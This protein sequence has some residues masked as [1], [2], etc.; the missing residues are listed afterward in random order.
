MFGFQKKLN[1]VME[2]LGILN[3]NLNCFK[4]IEFGHSPDLIQAK[5][6]IRSVFYL[7]KIFLSL[8]IS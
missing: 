2:D 7:F 8:F 5:Y 1:R 3:F 6:K 4:R